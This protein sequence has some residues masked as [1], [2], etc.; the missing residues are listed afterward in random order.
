MAVAAAGMVL[1]DIAAAQLAPVPD[2]SFTPASLGLANQEYERFGSA[3]ASGDFNCDG[4]DDLATGA[5]GWNANPALLDVGHV[6]IQY[7]TATGLTLGTHEW[8][9]PTVP[10][11]PFQGLTNDQFGWALASGD[12][13]G[14]GCDDL[15]IGMPGRD[16]HGQN[17]AGAVL[18]ILGG[19]THGLDTASGLLL[20][21]DIASVPEIAEPSDFFGEVLATGD[22]NADSIDDL[23]VGVRWESQMVG[24]NPLFTVGVVHLIPG[25]SS[26]LNIS[27]NQL[28]RPGDAGLPMAEEGEGFGWAVAFGDVYPFKA[29]DELVV[30]H[31]GRAVNSQDGAGMVSVV[32]D[33]GSSPDSNSYTQNSTNVAGVAESGDSFG[34]AVAVGDFNGDGQADIA[35]SAPQED[36]VGSLFDAGLVVL[37]DVGPL[38]NGSEGWHRSEIGGLET[39][40]SNFGEVLES[41]DFNADDIADLAI[42]LPNDDGDRG[43]QYIL[44]GASGSLLTNEGAQY[45]QP[46]LTCSSNANWG[47]ALASGHF[48]ARPGM[49]LA[50]AGENQEVAGLAQVGMTNLHYSDLLFRNGFD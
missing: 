38:P 6:A 4:L 33:L 32:F 26:G 21:Q 41:G 8:L 18:V 14:D 47:R 27:A 30:G 43:T 22:Y 45:F 7:A 10:G 49:G 20:H 46:C 48:D 39:A 42:G 16:I 34:A 31:P 13:D 28:I 19:A 5:S 23:A 44:Y 3:L 2:D 9:D 29:G 37:M 25:S 50:V 40:F 17:G 15:A 36:G 11:F 24:G 35:A 12:F 1:G